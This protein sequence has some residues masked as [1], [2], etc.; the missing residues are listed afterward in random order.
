M[1]CSAD[2]KGLGGQRGMAG[3]ACPPWHPSCNC[4]QAGEQPANRELR[5]PSAALPSLA[6]QVPT[7]STAGGSLAERFLE[8]AVPAANQHLWGSL[9]CTLLVH[10]S[11]EAAH[12]AAVQRALD[13]LQYGSVVV[14]SWSVAGFMAPQVG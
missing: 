12:P 13:G 4:L 14:N 5:S 1:E 11:T 6:G 7:G 3:G 2:R 10:P 8:A 9:S